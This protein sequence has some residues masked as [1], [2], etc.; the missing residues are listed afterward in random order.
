MNQW[1]TLRSAHIRPEKQHKS[2]QELLS[3][4]LARIQKLRSQ[5]EADIRYS[6][7]DGKRAS[8][9]DRNEL[10]SLSMIETELRAVIWDFNASVAG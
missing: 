3:Q 9:S 1:T 4:R 6:R 10:R 5:I 7:E 2:F 8:V